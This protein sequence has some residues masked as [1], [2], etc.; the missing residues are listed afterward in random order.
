MTYRSRRRADEHGKARPLLFN[1]AQSRLAVG[2]Q[3]LRQGR[4]YSE[5]GVKC[6]KIRTGASAQR[7]NVPR[8]GWWRGEELGQRRLGNFGALVRN[9]L[10]GWC[11]READKS[12]VGFDGAQVL[13][14][15]E[16]PG[17]TAPSGV[18]RQAVKEDMLRRAR[19]DSPDDNEQLSLTRLVQ[20]PG[21]ADVLGVGVDGKPQ[22]LARG[23]RCQ[24]RVGGEVFEGSDHSGACQREIEGARAHS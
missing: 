16:L 14:A 20:E 18:R 23:R 12:V 3:Q 15:R 21:E 19:N 24:R 22:G 1:V 8:E 9:G 6:N 4:G 13:E 11:D 7:V 5:R 2:V 17:V 10:E